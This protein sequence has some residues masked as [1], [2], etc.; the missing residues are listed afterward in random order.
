MFLDG[1]VCRAEPLRVLDGA[2][3][4]RRDGRLVPL[5]SIDP[6]PVALEM[7][8]GLVVAAGRRWSHRKAFLRDHDAAMAEPEV[9]RRELETVIGSG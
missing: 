4:V 2:W 7:L 8:E 6:A 9:G 5:D 1:N 3:V